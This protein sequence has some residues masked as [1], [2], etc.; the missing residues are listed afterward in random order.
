MRLTLLLV[1]ALFGL[2]KLAF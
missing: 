2:R 1:F